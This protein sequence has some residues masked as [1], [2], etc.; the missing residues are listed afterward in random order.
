[1]HRFVSVCLFSLVLAI[2]LGRPLGAECLNGDLSGDCRVNFEDV[3]SFADQWLDPAGSEADIVGDDGVDMADFAAL[4]RNWGK[5][6]SKVIINEIH[7]DP[8]VKT[9]LVEYVELV[10]RSAFDVDIGNWYFSNGIAYQFPAGTTLAAGGYVVVA[11]TPAQVASKF[12]VSSSLVFGPCVGKLSNEGERIVL[13]DAK[14]EQVDEVE[15]K[16]GFPWP[17]VG[18]PPG[19]SIELVNPAMDNDLGG[20][21]RPSEP[22]SVT[23]PTMLIE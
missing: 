9:E 18:G 2:L 16:L 15:Y 13:R 5:T 14:G 12:G 11:Q 3:W 19:Y 20:S 10:N 21:W 7:Y 23:P 8:D 1:M 6:R 4:A 22:D 17:T